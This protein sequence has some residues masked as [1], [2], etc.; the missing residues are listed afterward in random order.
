L[1]EPTLGLVLEHSFEHTGFVHEK[2]RHEPD[3]DRP[4]PVEAEPFRTFVAD[5]VGNAGR[6]PGDVRRRRRVLSHASARLP[7][8]S[9]YPGKNSRDSIAAREMQQRE[10]WPHPFH[11]SWIGA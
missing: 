1:V 2:L 4:H 7:T 6:H 11:H 3:E 8:A 5:D 9:A 10:S